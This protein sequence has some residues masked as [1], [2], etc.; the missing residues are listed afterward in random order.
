[1]FSA[2]QVREMSIEVDRQLMAARGMPI[3]DEKDAID[4]LRISNSKF[5]TS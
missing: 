2:E 4:E 3:A 5:R 1:M